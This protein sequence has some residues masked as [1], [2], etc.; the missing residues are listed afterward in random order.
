MRTYA[1][2]VMSN[3]LIDNNTS[4]VSKG[5]ITESSGCSLKTIAG[6]TKY[7]ELL[8]QYQEITR[9]AGALVKTNHSTSHYIETTFGPPVASKLE[10]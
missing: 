9:P 10:D 7:H 5:Q 3:R 8:E 1:V 6:S 2:C 4:L